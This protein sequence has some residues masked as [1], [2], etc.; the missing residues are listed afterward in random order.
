[1]LAQGLV[2]RGHEVIVFAHPECCDCGLAGRLARE[3]EPIRA[4]HLSE[5]GRLGRL[6]STGRFDLVHS[7]SR[8]GYLMPILPLA[9]ETYDL[10]ARDQPAVDPS[11]PRSSRDTLCSPRSVLDDANRG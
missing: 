4:R 5:C 9:A 7:F 8:I 2:A 10:S 3:V 1:M 11:R 6:G